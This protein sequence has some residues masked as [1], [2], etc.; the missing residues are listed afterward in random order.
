M[1]TTGS[2]GVT[3]LRAIGKT[4]EALDAQAYAA[5]VL[6]TTSFDGDI[7]GYGDIAG[8]YTV[9]VEFTAQAAS[10]GILGAD[11]VMQQIYPLQRL[12]GPYVGAFPGAP[13]HWYGGQLLPWSSTMPG[14]SP[15]AWVYFA[16][17]RDPL[18]DV[19]VGLL[20]LHLNLTTFQALQTMTLAATLARGPMPQ[21]VDAYIVIQVP[22]GS[23]FSLLGN[24]TV[25]P[26]IQP[27]A[28]GL[29]PFAASGELVRYTFT[30]AEPLGVYTWFGALLQAGTSNILGFIEQKSFTL[31]P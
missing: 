11:F 20:S 5:S 19:V 27:V 31:G 17:N 26:G 18:W 28:M 16:S 6:R 1:D 4:Q 21:L 25:V 30:G 13:D 8:P 10:A 29:V 14:V 3:F 22:G 2:W 7:A 15:T 9:A 23:L 24:G 12:S